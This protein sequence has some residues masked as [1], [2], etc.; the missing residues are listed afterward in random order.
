MHVWK[1]RQP[2]AGSLTHVELYVLVIRL[3]VSTLTSRPRVLVC[4]CV[5]VLLW[6]CVR[7]RLG[8]PRE[9]Q[10]DWEAPPGV[11]TDVL[12]VRPEH[13]V[14]TGLASPRECLHSA[15]STRFERT[16]LG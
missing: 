16:G 11:L 10:V 4:G 6:G 3:C 13:Q 8:E 9:S 2:H 7:V 5:G 1:R 12:L 14:A 15:H